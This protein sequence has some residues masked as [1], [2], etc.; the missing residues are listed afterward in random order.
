[1][2]E[3]MRLFQERKEKLEQEKRLRHDCNCDIGAEVKTLREKV[4]KLEAKVYMLGS[5]IR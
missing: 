3:A 4:A 1:M 2:S 5:D